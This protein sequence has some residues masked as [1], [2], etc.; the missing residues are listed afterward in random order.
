MTRTTSVK[1]AILQGPN[2][3]R[4]GKRRPDKYGT[5]TLAD[6]AADI[7]KTAGE[8][9][10]EVT[11]YQSN[12]EGALIDWLRTCQDE[13][14]GIVINPAGLTPYGRSLYD[15]LA[16]SDLPIAVVHMSAIFRYERQAHPDMFA[17]LASVYIAGL[18]AKGYPIAL[19]SL[20]EHIEDAGHV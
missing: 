2:L 5:H 20:C 4:L 14:D 18:R 8:L 11:Q 7:E 6:I 1:I 15:A 9:G 17:P 16:D 13:V 12:H 19:R 10:V 3:D